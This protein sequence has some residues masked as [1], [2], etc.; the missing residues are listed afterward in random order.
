MI[1]NTDTQTY[2]CMIS[3]CNTFRSKFQS[4][5]ELSGN[6]TLQEINGPAGLMHCSLVTTIR[7]LAAALAIMTLYF[8]GCKIWP[9]MINV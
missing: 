7:M 6:F 9:D 3:I 8:T 1:M 2:K 4:S 5:K